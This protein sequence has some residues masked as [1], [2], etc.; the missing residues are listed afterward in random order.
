MLVADR[1]RT[2][3]K[4]SM[5]CLHWQM[6]WCIKGL[7]NHAILKVATNVELLRT[8]TKGSGN[9]KVEWISCRRKYATVSK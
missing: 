8:H 3:T 1:E 7:M 6:V 4:R 5:G 9:I 2:S